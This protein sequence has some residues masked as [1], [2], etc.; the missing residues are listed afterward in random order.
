MSSRSSTKTLHLCLPPG[1][2]SRRQQMTVSPASSPD[3]GLSHGRR[4]AGRWT[5]GK[6][7]E[8]FT[9]GSRMATLL[10]EVT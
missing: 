8:R 5:R 3:G 4:S 10:T 9:M 6:V 1:L 2:S 7:Q